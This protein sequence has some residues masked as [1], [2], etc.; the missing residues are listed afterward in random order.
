MAYLLT[1]SQVQHAFIQISMKADPDFGFN[2]DKITRTVDQWAH[3][4]N[5]GV[6]RIYKDGKAKVWRTIMIESYAYVPEPSASDHE[7][8]DDDVAVPTR[9]PA[10]AVFDRSSPVAPDVTV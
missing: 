1:F 8:S 4:E 9:N 3:T 6:G 7:E 2:E 5:G 10:S